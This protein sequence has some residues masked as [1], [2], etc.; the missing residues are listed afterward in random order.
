MFLSNF[1]IADK[2]AAQWV[3]QKGFEALS[4]GS[5]QCLYPEFLDYSN[6]NCFNFSPVSYIDFFL[7][8]FSRK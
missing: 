6:Q 2:L 5:N 4:T 7:R 1:V 3:A 8:K